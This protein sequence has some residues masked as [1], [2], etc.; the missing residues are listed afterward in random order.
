MHKIE[1]KNRNIDPPQKSKNDSIDSKLK[2]IKKGTNISTSIE[3]IDAMDEALSPDQRRIFGKYGGKLAGYV[4]AG[5]EVVYN[6]V[7]YNNGRISG[8][9]FTYRLGKTATTMII[10]SSIAGPKGVALGV[11]VGLTFDLVEKGW[12]KFYSDTKQSV[13]RFEN[14]MVSNWM[15]YK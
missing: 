13:N 9:R 1:A 11:L 4:A 7:E 10:G 6:G 14:T 2:D 5:G 8:Y 12:D 15:K 3:L